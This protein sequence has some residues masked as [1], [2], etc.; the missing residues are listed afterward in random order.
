[1]ICVMCMSCI[2]V[3]CV[4]SVCVFRGEGCEF[5]LNGSSF[6]LIAVIDV[7][8]CLLTQ[9]TRLSLIIIVLA[10]C[11]ISVFCVVYCLITVFAFFVVIAFLSEVSCLETIRANLFHWFFLIGEFEWVCWTKYG[12]W[13]F[14][15][16]LV[17]RHGDIEIT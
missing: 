6:E 17:L 12:G 9:W 10:L 13:Y 4:C 7:M 16:E 11:V 2:V 5:D 1:V 14:T 3:V 8:V 15:E